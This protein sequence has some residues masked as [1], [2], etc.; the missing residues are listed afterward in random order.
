MRIS[1]AASVPT[2]APIVFAAY[3]RPND[4]VSEPPVV[5]WRIRLGNVAPMRIVAGAS[6]STASSN[7]MSGRAAVPSIDA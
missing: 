2:I 7:R 1:P 6:A 5:R 3:R 4:F